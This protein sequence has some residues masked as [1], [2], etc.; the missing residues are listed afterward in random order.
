MSS[1]DR[2]WGVPFCGGVEGGDRAGLAEG[3]VAAEQ[4]P[5]PP[6]HRGLEVG[7]LER[8]GVGRAGVDVLDG[9]V[10]PAQLDDRVAAVPG[11][12]EEQRALGAD[13]LELRAAG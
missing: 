8:I 7:Q 9:A 2:A 5:V 12:G 1:S 11:I 13:G 4:R 10:G 3:V 6:A